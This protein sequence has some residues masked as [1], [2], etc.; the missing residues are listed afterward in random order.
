MKK[1]IL[2]ITAFLCATFA[3]AEVESKKIYFYDIEYDAAYTPFIQDGENR[4]WGGEDKVHLGNYDYQDTYTS[5]NVREFNT[6]SLTFNQVDSIEFKINNAYGMSG[7]NLVPEDLEAFDIAFYSGGTGN[8]DTD[9]EH[10][11]FTLISKIED[12]SLADMKAGVLLDNLNWNISDESYITLIMT[13]DETLV[14]AV[15][16]NTETAGMSLAASNAYITI[17]GSTAAVPEP[18]TYAAIFGAI[19]LGFVVYRRRK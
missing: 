9:Y 10:S 2:T 16:G 12:I 6:S 4:T 5:L 14:P 3:F 7:S 13:V 19:A 8:A 17:T 1:L 11:V 18:S 15:F